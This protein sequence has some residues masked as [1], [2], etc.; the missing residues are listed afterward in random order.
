MIIEDLPSDDNLSS[1][2]EPS[3]WEVIPIPSPT[4]GRLTKKIPTR[5]YASV[6]SSTINAS[7]K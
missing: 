2:E 5:T 3:D 7:S 6:V 4:P 1:E